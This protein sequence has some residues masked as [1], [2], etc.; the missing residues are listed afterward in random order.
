MF[1]I[2]ALTGAG[3]LNLA[4]NRIC[5]VSAASGFYGT[6]RMSSGARFEMDSDGGSMSADVYA[7]NGACF[8]AAA[9]APIRTSGRIVLPSEA[10]VMLDSVDCDDFPLN[11]LEASRITKGDVVWN[12]V[13]SQGIPLLSDRYKVC[14]TDSGLSVKMRK[15]TTVIIR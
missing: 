14:E 13:D 15:G 9:V 3:I 10:T 7:E 1:S 4:E 6:V 5:Q 2:G 12:F 11:I 8:K